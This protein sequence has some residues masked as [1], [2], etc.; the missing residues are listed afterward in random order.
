MVDLCGRWVKNVSRGVGTDKTRTSHRVR[1]TSLAMVE[2][3]M[4]PGEGDDIS[5]RCMIPSIAHPMSIRALG[6]SAK[7][8]FTADLSKVAVTGPDKRSP[9]SG[10]KR[11]PPRDVDLPWILQRHLGGP[12]GD[13]PGTLQITHPHVIPLFVLGSSV[14]R[15]SSHSQRFVQP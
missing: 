5:Y 14:T 3:E 13:L 6:R 10:G 7:N 2:I 8:E 15:L 11:Y 9:V 4:N 1:L 12:L